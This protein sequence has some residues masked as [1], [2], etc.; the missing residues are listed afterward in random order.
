[1]SEPVIDTKG[2]HLYTRARLDG[3]GVWTMSFVRSDPVGV[4]E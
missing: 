4:T 2:D 1:M 3:A